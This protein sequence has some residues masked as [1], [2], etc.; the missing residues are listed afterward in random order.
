MKSTKITYKTA[1]VLA[2][3]IRA[4]RANGRVN[5]E[6]VNEDG[7]EY[8]PNRLIITNAVNKNQFT[9]DEFDAAEQIK[10]YLKDV[11]II[12][13]LKQGTAD[14]FLKNMIEMLELESVTARE[15]GLM[16]WAPKLSADYQ[17]R[18]R[19]REASAL[20]ES[21]SRHF[22]NTGDRVEIDFV[23]IE[24][25]FLKNY[26]CYRVYGHT[27]TGDLVS[28]WARDSKKIIE[29]GRLKGRVNKHVTDS[30]RGGACVTML[31]YVK[32]I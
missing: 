25:V 14:Q 28:Y 8:Q 1:L 18:D 31:N 17:R 12:Q 7:V 5:R 32:V 21:T 24:S 6:F 11:A 23:L 2:A 20:Y 29:Q 4:Y 10:T 13:T 15:F 22:G 19:T 30:H 26:D 16:A 27:G 9:A 3:A